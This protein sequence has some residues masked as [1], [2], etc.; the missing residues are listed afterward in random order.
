MLTPLPHVPAVVGWTRISPSAVIGVTVDDGDSHASLAV[1][2]RRRQV[3]VTLDALALLELVAVLVE[4]A[5]RLQ[6]T[7]VSPEV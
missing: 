7:S 5:E 1:S 6:A 3:L 4:A 2:D